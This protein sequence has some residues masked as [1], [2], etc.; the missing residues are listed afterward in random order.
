MLGTVHFRV[1]PDV[2]LALA[3]HAN[4]CDANTLPATMA[5]LITK[6]LLF[7]ALLELWLQ[8]FSRLSC[9]ILR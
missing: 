3:A 2:G 9:Q 6:C 4:A 5:E 7:L 8:E 1:R